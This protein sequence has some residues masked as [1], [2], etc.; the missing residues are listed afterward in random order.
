MDNAWFCC[1]MKNK[2]FIF[3]PGDTTASGRDMSNA[4]MLPNI[5]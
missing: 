1:A 5:K 2:H 4:A 3:L